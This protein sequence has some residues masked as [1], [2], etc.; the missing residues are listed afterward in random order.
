MAAPM[1]SRAERRRYRWADITLRLWRPL[2]LL[3][4]WHYP[5][6]DGRLARRLCPCHYHR[7]DR[8]SRRLSE[9]AGAWFAAF[10]ARAGKP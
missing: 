3:T 1:L 7:L 5:R 6:Q 4:D 9:A 8:E 10:Y 2:D